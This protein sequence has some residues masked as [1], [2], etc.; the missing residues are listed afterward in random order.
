M[1]G[2]GEGEGHISAFGCITVPGRHTSTYP[3]QV[4]LR[5]RYALNTDTRQVVYCKGVPPRMGGG[6][7]DVCILDLATQTSTIV[8]TTS[9]CGGNPSWENDS[10]VCARDSTTGKEA[11]FPTRR[12]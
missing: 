6:S 8:G 11:R 9:L 3:V 4:R 1:R 7:A 10:T 12:Q 5:W 2:T